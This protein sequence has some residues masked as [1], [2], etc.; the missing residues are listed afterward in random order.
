MI[1]TSIKH[2]KNQLETCFRYCD[3][4]NVNLLDAVLQYRFLELYRSITDF[5]ITKGDVLKVCLLYCGVK[6]MT[7]LN[8]KAGRITVTSLSEY[9]AV[10]NKY[11]QRNID[12]EYL[13]KE[14]QKEYGWLKVRGKPVGDIGAN[15]GDSAIYFVRKGASH[16][17][18]YEPYPYS[19]KH[20]KINIKKMRCSSKITLYN[21]AVGSKR[22]VVHLNAKYRSDGG[23]TLKNF[24]IGK[25][26]KVV[27]LEDIIKDNGVKSGELKVDCEGSEYGILLSASNHDLRIFKQIVIEYHYGY[28]NLKK[29]L[30]DAGFRVTKTRPRRVLN[31]QA[32]N[33]NMVVGLMFAERI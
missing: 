22:G 12:I 31:V 23:T 21:Q 24:K 20:A 33:P 19:Y 27:T 10:L 17:Y 14:M 18:S 7:V 16:V 5:V 32:S 9:K 3:K 2:A 28:L 26:I 11:H 8:T 6:S 1:T 30:E 4:M 25:K 15:V 29:K 13:V